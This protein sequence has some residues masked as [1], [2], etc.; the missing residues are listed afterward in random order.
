MWVFFLFHQ[1]PHTKVQWINSGGT[2]TKT[3]LV[4]TWYFTSAHNSDTTLNINYLARTRSIASLPCKIVREIDT[5]LF[6]KSFYHKGFFAVKRRVV[7]I[8]EAT[9]IALVRGWRRDWVVGGMETRFQ[10]RKAHSRTAKCEA[11]HVAPRL[12][13]MFFVFDSIHDSATMHNHCPQ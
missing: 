6:K 9:W 7:F 3:N 8:L 13:F 5:T 12:F 2:E 1:L 10:W 11:F 4:G